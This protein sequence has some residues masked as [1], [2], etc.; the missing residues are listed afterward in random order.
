MSGVNWKETPSTS[1]KKYKTGLH[2]QSILPKFDA[3]NAPGEDQL[4]Q[5]FYY[6]LRPSIKLWIADIEENMPWDDLIKA[7]NKAEARTKIHE[8]IH[9]D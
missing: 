9:L 7:A 4:G 8:S 6:C 1:W 3:N 5:T 2:T